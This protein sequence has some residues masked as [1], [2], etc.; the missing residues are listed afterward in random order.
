VTV[1]EN[2]TEEKTETYTVRVPHTVTKQVPVTVRRCV[3]E[4]VDACDAGCSSANRSSTAR[5][6]GL[7]GRGCRRCHKAC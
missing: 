5:K 4:E 7:L 2:V 1:C 6:G 3:E